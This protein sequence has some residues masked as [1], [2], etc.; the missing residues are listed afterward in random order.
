LPKRVYR[1][2]PLSPCASPRAFPGS[3]IQ[4]ELAGVGENNFAIIV[5][6]MLI[7]PQA[8]IGLGVG[9]RRQSTSAYGVGDMMPGLC[10]MIAGIALVGCG[11]AVTYT[12]Y[13]NSVVVP[14]AR[15]HVATFDRPPAFGYEPT[16]E[17]AMAAFAKHW[18]GS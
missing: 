18:R 4:P 3:S 14:G 6:Q 10:I 11:D 8:R 13:R 7:G 9:N 2:N 17:A 16:R 5:R 1:P 15:L 12:L